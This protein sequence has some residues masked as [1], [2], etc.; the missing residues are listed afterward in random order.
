MVNANRIYYFGCL[1][2]IILLKEREREKPLCLG[3]G[4]GGQPSQPP[5]LITRFH[6]SDKKERNC[7]QKVA[8]LWVMT[9]GY[10]Q[11]LSNIINRPLIN[12]SARTVFSRLFMTTTC[13]LLFRDLSIFLSH[14]P[15]YVIFVHI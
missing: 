11:Y 4:G 1:A 15:N 12:L 2:N 14:H 13:L 9:I 5:F 8:Q 6:C 7:T 10:P 3:V